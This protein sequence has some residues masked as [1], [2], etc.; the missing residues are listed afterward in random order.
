MLKIKHEMSQLQ[1]LL[2]EKKDI[3]NI[4]MHNITKCLH[5]KPPTS[6]LCVSCHYA[7]LWIKQNVL[8]KSTAAILKYA[9][10]NIYLNQR[11]SVLRNEN[12]CLVGQEW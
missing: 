5:M 9:K 2:Q 8:E 11:R 4:H 10:I 1:S 3:S 7:S 12:L 6:F